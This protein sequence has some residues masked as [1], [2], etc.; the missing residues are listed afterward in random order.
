MIYIITANIPCNDS[1]HFC[2]TVDVQFIKA[3]KN[4]V[5]KSKYQYVGVR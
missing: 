4:P 1:E 3:T 5:A 2:C